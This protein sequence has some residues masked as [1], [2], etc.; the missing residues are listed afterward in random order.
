MPEGNEAFSVLREA[1]VLNL[2]EMETV[3]DLF[4]C[5]RNV[6]TQPEIPEKADYVRVMSLHKSK[7]LTSKVTI[8]SGCAQGL[9]PFVNSEAPQGE[10]Q[11][12]MQE[13]RRLF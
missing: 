12:I 4:D 6:V 13:Q 9:I 7:G 5:V 10:A 8:V 3:D 2:T 11:A 1:A